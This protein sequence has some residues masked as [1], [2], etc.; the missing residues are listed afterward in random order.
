MKRV[1]NYFSYDEAIA[2]GKIPAS[3]DFLHVADSD[4]PIYT[5]NTLLTPDQCDAAVRKLLDHG[6]GRALT[7]TAGNLANERKTVYLHIGEDENA[8]FSEVFDSVKDE[9]E[10][11]Y[12]LRITAS[13]DVNALGY[14]PGG[15]YRAH[16]DNCAPVFD[17]NGRMT[18]FDH[19]MP[20]RALTT[21]LFLTDSVDEITTENQ[22]IGGNIALNRMRNDDGDPFLIEPKKGLLITFPSNPYYQH[23]VYPVYEG[24]RVSMV[25]W[26]SADFL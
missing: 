23:Q 18:G 15:E 11:F 13:E 25:N 1:S 21:I 24:F 8:F 19:N 7:T 9:I 6:I 26:H 4:Y 10:A 3:A 20:D 16:C 17:S 14:P 22:C 2:P 5:K 12:K